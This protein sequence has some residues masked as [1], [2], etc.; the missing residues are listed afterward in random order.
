VTTKRQWVDET[1]RV[2]TLYTNAQAEKVVIS[3]VLRDE[4]EIDLPDLLARLLPTHFVS[5]KPA[6]HIWQIMRDLLAEGKTYGYMEV[7]ARLKETTTLYGNEELIAAMSEW[8]GIHQVEPCVKIL[9]ETRRRIDLIEIAQ[10]IMERASHEDAAGIAAASRER[11][12]ALL[13][14]GRVEAHALPDLVKKLSDRLD[15][16]VVP[17]RPRPTG[18]ARVDY[19]L[20]GGLRPGQLVAVGARTSH[21]KTAFGI[22]NI[23]LACAR[24][25]FRVAII[26]LEMTEDELAAR[27]LSAISAIP[28]MTLIQGAIPADDMRRYVAA[29]A[30]ASRADV[31]IFTP[32]QKSLAN[33]VR[34]IR[35]SVRRNQSEI[36]FVDY[37]QLIRHEDGKLTR[38][39]AVTEITATLKN[40]A[41]ELKIPIV[42]LGQLNRTADGIQPR[43]AHFR[44][45]GSI[46]QD[47]DIALLLW[48]PDDETGEPQDVGYILVDKNRNGKKGRANVVFMGDSCSFEAT[49]AEPAI[50]RRKTAK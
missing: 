6:P 28:V 29:A 32:R 45:C 15:G 26:T 41:T 20:A 1:V 33:I 37:L 11:L 40:L 22:S 14:G 10:T 5:W 46:E 4:T 2:S 43:S 23:A 34:I 30:E 31:Q 42:I 38:V 39:E 19:L 21:G 13:D 27:Y 7:W 35:Q 47:A 12:D 25:G 17:L 3:A 24:A 36:I 18:L 49:L 48:R 50:P 8:R 44:E 16:P 9:E